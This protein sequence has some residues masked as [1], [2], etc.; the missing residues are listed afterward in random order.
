MITEASVRGLRFRVLERVEAPAKVFRL[1]GLGLRVAE[2]QALTPQT[3]AQ[4][5]Q[6]FRVAT[7]RSASARPRAN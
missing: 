1:G 4:A 2:A 6:G 7:G 5:L 3:E